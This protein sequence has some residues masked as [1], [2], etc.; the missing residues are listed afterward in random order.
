M[1]D[2]DEYKVILRGMGY[3]PLSKNIYAKPV[4]Y[5]IFVFYLPQMLWKNCFQTKQEE[6]DIWNSEQYNCEE[7]LEFVKDFTQF[8]KEAENMNRTESVNLPSEFQFITA[9]DRI[10]LINEKLMGSK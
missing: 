1:K 7:T 5:F 4:G 2:L 10:A 6:M 3:R 8:I 9:D